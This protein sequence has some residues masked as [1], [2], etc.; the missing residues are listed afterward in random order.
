MRKILVVF[1]ALFFAV[2]VFAQ[3]LYWQTKTEGTVAER[4]TDNFA[5]PGK[6]KIVRTGDESEG[7]IIIARLDK[8]VFWMLNPEKKTYSEMTF[9]E[10]EKMV[11]KAGAKLDDAMSKMQEEMKDMTPEQR[12]M[13]EKMMGGKMHGAQRASKIDIQK[14]EK[15]KTIGGYSCTKYTV[16]QDENEFMT[17]WVTKG[18][19]GF[20]AMAAD[21]K[22]FAER[23]STMSPQSAKGMA[24]AYKKVDGFP[25]Q[26][27][28]NMMGQTVTTTVT[29][30]ERRSTPA[31]EF[32][33]PAGYKKV[34]GEWKKHMQ[35]MEQHE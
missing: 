27:V 9:A 13:V 34:E 15:T 32:D 10:M 12:A 23:M 21:W 20:D 14:S 5:M 35:E 24:E 28:M 8:E 4:A 6:F 7:A 11:N 33:I 30:V 1:M 25:M 18:V 3:G 31:K 2:S 22:K 17:L 16:K 26:T 19:S 29:T